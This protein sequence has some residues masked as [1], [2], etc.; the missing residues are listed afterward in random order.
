MQGL[1]AI[2]FAFMNGDL[3][4]QLALT[5]VPQI[6][7]VH[8]RI[9]VQHF[10]SARDIFKAPLAILEKIEGIGTVRARSI[11]SFKQFEEAEKEIAFI[12][13]YRVR[14][15]FLTDAAYPQ[16]LLNCYDPPTLLFY[17]GRADLN[18]A[19]IVS[20][21]GTRN[22]T[23]YGKHV[24]EKFIKDLTPHGVLVISGL[25][26]GIDAQA[27]KSALKNDLSTVGVLAH[28][29]DA[30]YPPEHAA[31]ARDMIKKNGGLLTEFRSGTKPDKHHFPTRNRIV[32]GMSDAVVVVETG[33]KGG[34]MITAE[35]ANGYHKD[36]FAFPGRVSD[37][38]SA[39]CN[40]LIKNNKAVL[41]TR[42]ADLV[43]LMGWEEKEIVKKKKQKEIFIELS[44][45]ERVIVEVLQEKECVPID[46]IHQ[47]CA[48][49]NSAVA[50]SLLNLELQQVIESLPGKVYRLLPVIFVTFGVLSN[51][52][53]TKL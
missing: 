41:I 53:V 6:G 5:Q 39:G 9:L 4:Y 8:A 16:R 18:C 22:N 26:F 42:A 44:G 49:S 37:A 45:P 36:V 20:V 52:L 13:K 38:K 19:H 14:S 24:T 23:E 43:N 3:L 30:M 50:A 47:R 21:I 46:E 17:H 35:L 33:V 40:E 1:L 51:W 11:R 34:S 12:E 10:G 15:L 2:K 7:H 31:L 28:G 32:A 27:H 48:L 29:L 25:A